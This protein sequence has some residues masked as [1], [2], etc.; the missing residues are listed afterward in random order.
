[1]STSPIIGLPELEHFRGYEVLRGLLRV[2]EQ[3]SRPS[4]AIS[5]DGR[6]LVDGMVQDGTKLG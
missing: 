6:R 4:I 3:G 2:S 5:D 1:M